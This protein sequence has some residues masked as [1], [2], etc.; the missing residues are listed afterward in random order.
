MVKNR[1]NTFDS[2]QFFSPVI[3]I[4][5]LCLGFVPNLSAVDKIAPQWIGMTLLNLVSLSA[6]IF[7]TNYF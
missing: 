5:Y 4:G 2:F 7:K 1:T 3:L 6:I